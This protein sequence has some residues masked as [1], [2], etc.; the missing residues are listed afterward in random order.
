MNVESRANCQHILAPC[1]PYGE[2]RIVSQ[3][4]SDLSSGSGIHSGD[5]PVLTYLKSPCAGTSFVTKEFST[6][7]FGNSR[8]YLRVAANCL[9]PFIVRYPVW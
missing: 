3:K 1:P 5:Y 6:S 4:N 8:L 7:R 9:N 2:A